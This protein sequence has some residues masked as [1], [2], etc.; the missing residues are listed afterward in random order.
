MVDRML[1]E[2]KTDVNCSR[3]GHE[4]KIFYF[5]YL[6][7]KSKYTDI[8]YVNLYYTLSKYNN[9]YDIIP[10]ENIAFYILTYQWTIFKNSSL[11]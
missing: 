5:I 1:G 6:S 10:L 8:G 7:C 4:G 2:V 11:R 9:D 3:S